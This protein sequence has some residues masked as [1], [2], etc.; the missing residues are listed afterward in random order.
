MEALFQKASKL[1]RVDIVRPD[2]AIGTNTVMS[3]Q[4]G[5]VRGYAGAIQGIVG[6]MQEEMG[7]KCNVV[8]TGGMGRM[9]AQYCDII[10]HVDANLTLEGLLMIYQANKE[11]FDAVET[12]GT[13]CVSADEEIETRL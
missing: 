11:K 7:C 12:L 8:A 10:T 4:S 2:K 9:M 6:E 5:A 13:L 1:P 3:M